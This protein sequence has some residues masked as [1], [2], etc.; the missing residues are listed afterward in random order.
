MGSYRKSSSG[1]SLLLHWDP[2]LELSLW[3]TERLEAREVQGSHSASLHSSLLIAH[4]VNKLVFLA[5]LTL[6]HM[7]P[8]MLPN[9]E[10]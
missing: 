10:L 4:R 8:R 9:T 7:F 5:F 2:A 1:P 6:V 3:E